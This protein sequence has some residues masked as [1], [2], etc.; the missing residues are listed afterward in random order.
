MTSRLPIKLLMICAGTVLA[1]QVFAADTN[2][3]SSPTAP[4]PDAVTQ[5]VANGY[6]QIQEQLHATQL[7]IADS[8]EQAAAEAATNAAV[9]TARIQTLE[10]AIA[11]Q[12][13]SDNDAA[14]RS[15][16]MMLYAIGAFGLIGMG[17][18]VLMAY[19]QWR[20]FAQ[21]AEIS[22]RQNA[23]I[24]LANGVHQL[25]APGRATVDASNGRL[26]DVVG[27]LERRIL[28]LES[29]QHIVLPP[30]PTKSEDLLADAQKFID[31][32]APQK[33]L[34]CANLLLAAQPQHAEAL[35]KKAAALDLLGRLDEALICCDRAIA[36]NPS[37]VTAYLQK[38]GLLN[39]LTRYDEALNCFEQALLA[40]E[41]KS[42]ARVMA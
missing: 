42:T 33:A 15:Q 41:K 30:A 16:Q 24:A 39:R 37:L 23:A 6:L 14:H 40:Q 5:A 3:L 17:I 4:V 10:Q 35:V 36:A 21:L 13:A 11:V 20:A 25:A 9:L 26:L 2:S 12:R 18:M 27:Q 19:F 32:N 34:E 31:A 28:E 1:A 7:A 22:A 29:E 38:G 8:R